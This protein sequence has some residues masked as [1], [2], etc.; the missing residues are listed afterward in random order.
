MNDRK[1]NQIEELLDA[2]LDLEP[3]K[4]K[5]FLDQACGDNHELRKE[6]EALLAADERAQS[7]I[8]APALLQH[9]NLL[10]KDHSELFDRPFPFIFGHYQVLRKIGEGG[11]GAVY[12][13]E[14]KSLSRKVALKILRQVFTKEP[15]RLQRFQNEARAAS[16]L[17][18]PNILTVYETGQENGI[19]FIATEYVEGRTLRVQL[20]AGKIKIRDAVEITIQICNALAPAHEAG[21]VHRDIKPENIMLRPDGIVK[22][23][24]FGVAKM[25][26]IADS[27]EETKTNLT[28]EGE[29][30]GTV[31][32]MSPEQVR[33]QAVDAR[34]DIFSLGIVL[35]EMLTGAVPFEG[36]T[37]SDVIAA[38]LNTEVSDMSKYLP[39]VPK[40][41]ETIVIKM[42][43]KDPKDRYQ[44]EKELLNDL[45]PLKQNLDSSAD[46]DR[47]QKSTSTR[48]PQISF[49]FLAITL[50]ILLVALAGYWYR[51]KNKSPN[52]ESIA[53]LPFINEG[54][55]SELEY[56]T[57][58]I[59]E[60][61]IRQ[62]SR[63]PNLKVMARSTMFRY[64]KKE[65]DARTVGKDLGVQAV[66]TGRVVQKQN[67]LQITL[68]LADARD[69][70]YIWSNQYHGKINNLLSIQSQIA[71]DI[72]NRLTTGGKLIA[73]SST[74]NEEAYSLYL[75][76]RFFWNKR[77]KDGLEKAITYFRQALDVD[78]NYA[79]AWSGLADCYISQTF[80][81]YSSPKEA[82]P[83][84]KAAAMKALEIDESLAEAHITLAHVA[85]NFD[86]DWKTSEKEFKRGIELNPNYA[87]G[88]QW[89]AMHYLMPIPRFNDALAELKMAQQ[90]DP[91]SP[92][93]TSFLG[94]AFY[95]NRHYKE[96]EN[97]CRKALELEP[98]FPVAHWHLG[99][100]YEQQGLYD[101]AISEHQKA[102]ELSGGSPRLIAALGHAYAKAGKREEALQV[103]TQL[104][105][106]EYVSALEVASI[107]LAL[108]D[109]K[110]VFEFLNRAFNERSFHITYIKIRPEF[111]SIRNDP[112]FEDLIRKI[113]L[114]S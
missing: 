41:L 44:T 108:G 40:E 39:G 91:L 98:N 50:A 101:E 29:V 74:E 114:Q 77:T 15:G 31:K 54:K 21:I 9:S 1:W 35:F 85:V 82:M 68:E 104:N 7:F 59:T 67:D 32:Y 12:L 37:K 18:H 66:L 105:Q 38:I 33:G 24:D 49:K 79:L 61:I 51:S 81:E 83:L 71:N 19:H 86:W 22:V 11:M 100:I 34:S 25:I 42:L 112:R 62:L 45:K 8:E 97:E 16:S 26:Q 30:I 46:T 23:V 2:A 43:Q 60:T 90:L 52:I 6:V 88:H 84:A 89:Y 65:V 53:V 111:D 102:I 87:T 47:I 73:E 20:S 14:D 78:P 70:S 107:H 99:L 55:Q 5:N 36:K 48:V 95:F 10:S 4:R 63:Q 28:I 106:R 64:K 92:L 109:K 110:N 113:G 17:N 76:G 69:N 96:A 27:N 72:S 58:G 94:E 93:M 57:D 3:K 13:A 80:Y 75:K 103:I 56:L